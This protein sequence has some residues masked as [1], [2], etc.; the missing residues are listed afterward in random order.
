[1]NDLPKGCLIEPILLCLQ[2]LS[3]DEDAAVPTC[4][5]AETIHNK[6]LQASGNNMTNL[7]DAI[8]DDYCRAALQ[9]TGF[10]NFLKEWGGRTGPDHKVLKLRSATHSGDPKRIAQAISDLSFDVGLN[11]RVSYLEGQSI[12]E[13][14][15]WKLDLLPGDDRLLL[16]Q[17]CKL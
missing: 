8:L 14:M 10:H 5:L 7:Y 12:F 9:S 1:M 3:A 4:N 15:K 16:S 13:S 2:V 6:W 17:P 11:S